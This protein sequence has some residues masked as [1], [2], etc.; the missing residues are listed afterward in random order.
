MSLGLERLVY[1]SRA[2]G[3]T[4]SLL[5]LVAILGESQRN[6]VRDGVTGV[7][8]A[9]GDRFIQVLEGS[10]GALDRLTRRLVEDRRHRDMTILERTPIGERLF[11]RWVMA[12]ARIKPEAAPMGSTILVD[13][14]DKPMWVPKFATG[15]GELIPN[16][17]LFDPTRPKTDIQ[18]LTVESP[19]R[20]VG[21]GAH[22][23]PDNEWGR[24]IGAAFL[25]DWKS[26]VNQLNS[27]GSPRAD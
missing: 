23:A 5:N 14:L 4:T 7:L 11:D 15:E 8:A 24:A 9:H 25:T 18:I 20:E 16:P 26:L 17:E 22:S 1:E 27:P 2:T 13:T 10:G 6:N 12:S 21:I 19:A 3:S